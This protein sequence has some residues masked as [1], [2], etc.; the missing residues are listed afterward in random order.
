M[1]TC[2]VTHTSA[3]TI[4]FR[5]IR[6]DTRPIT[7]TSHETQA[8]SRPKYD[9]R[10]WTLGVMGDPAHMRVRGLQRAA[11]ALAW[12]V[13][14]CVCVRWCATPHLLLAHR[15]PPQDSHPAAI[16]IGDGRQGEGGNEQENSPDSPASLAVITSPL[17]P[18][19]P[20]PSLAFSPEG[21][22]R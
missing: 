13:R 4:W 2:R 7:T 11:C 15:K 17:F 12:V 5:S 19:S 10:A 18:L 8:W 1:V 3:T 21:G 14:V 6:P 22:Q 16:L 20:S 9:M